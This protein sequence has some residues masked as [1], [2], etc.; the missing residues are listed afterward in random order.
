MK[1]EKRHLWIAL[2]VLAATILFNVRGS[3]RPGSASGQPAQRPLLAGLEVPGGIGT[4]GALDTTT[5]PAP[6]PVDLQT[7]PGWARDP[8]VFGG[9]SR[10]VGVMPVA[11]APPLPEPVVRSIL[12]SPSRRLAIV[13]GRIVGIGDRAGAYEIVDIERAVVVVRDAA[14]HRRRLEVHAAAPAGVRR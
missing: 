13:D 10:D 4:P 8:F 1:L 3:L 9:E 14:G 7:A 6:P 5:I 11:A 2:A 12:Y